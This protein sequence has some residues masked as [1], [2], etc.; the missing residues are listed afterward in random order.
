MMQQYKV[1]R[2]VIQITPRKPVQKTVTPTQTIQTP[3][4]LRL[5]LVKAGVIS[6]TAK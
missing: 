6:P 1:G 5:N 3:P 2:G 4:Q